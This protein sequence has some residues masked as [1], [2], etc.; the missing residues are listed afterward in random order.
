MHSK[1]LTPD[2]VVV[3]IAMPGLDGLQVIE[4][5]Q[6][7]DLPTQALVL[8]MHDEEV[9]VRRALRSGAR[10]YLL[11]TSVAQELVLA[12]QA[13]SRGETYLSPAVAGYVVDRFLEHEAGEPLTLAER[14]TP[15]EHQVLQ[16]IAEGHTSRDIA[17][18]PH[19]SPR[20]VEEHRA[21]LMSKLGAGNLAELLRKA[22]EHRLV[23]IEEYPA[24]LE[25][26]S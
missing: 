22:I 26:N 12:I 16:L 4:Q 9:L 17:Q 13:A 10:G 6:L 11:K 18:M 3:D 8:S 25:K 15:R 21:K 23:H 1:R 14:L 7:L 24:S 2:V 19:L 5:I 20:T